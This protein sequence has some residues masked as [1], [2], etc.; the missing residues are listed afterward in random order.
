MKLTHRQATN[1]EQATLKCCVMRLN[2]MQ[3]SKKVNR[4]VELDD[5]TV[6]PTNYKINLPTNNNVLAYC[7][8]DFNVIIGGL[9]QKLDNE[10]SITDL[11]VS[12]P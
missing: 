1:E 7:S 9:K 10:S 3:C 4:V 12:F 8:A 5:L 11:D 2:H 6:L